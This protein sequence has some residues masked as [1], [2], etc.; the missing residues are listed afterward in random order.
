MESLDEMLKKPDA[1]IAVVG[2]T[3][4]EKKY[5]YVIYRDLKRKGY[6]VP[7]QPLP[8]HR[9]RRPGLRRLPICPSRRHHRHG[10][11]ARGGVKVVRRPRHQLRPIWLQPGAESPGAAILQEAD[12]DYI[13][14][15]CIMVRP[16]R[17]SAAG[18]P[19]R[20]SRRS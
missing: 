9:G 20:R 17:P 4:D 13:A 5:G 18:G 2:A 3:D 8:R 14:N 6:R 10:R 19:Q 7:G 12:A 15:A 1:T 16:P 11:P